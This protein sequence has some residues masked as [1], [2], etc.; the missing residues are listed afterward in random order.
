MVNADKVSGYAAEPVAWAV[1]AGLI[2]GSEV[3]VNGVAAKDLNPRGNTT[4]AQVATILQ[5]F[6]EKT[7]ETPDEEPINVEDVYGLKIAFEKETDISIYE[8]YLDADTTGKDDIGE[9]VEP[10]ILQPSEEVTTP[11]NIALGKPVTV[12]GTSDG[13]KSGVNDGTD[14]KWD[15]DPIKGS[16][17]KENSWVYVD[18]GADKTSIFDFMKIKY[19]NKIYPTLME[20]QISNDGKNWVTVSEFTREH[21]GTTYP[22]VDDVYEPALTARYV[23]LFFEELNSAAA[24][25]GVGVIEWEIQ[26]ITLSNVSVKSVAAVDGIQAAVNTSAANLNLP[27][28]V[29]VVLKQSVVGDVEVLV[30]VTWDTANYNGSAAGTYTLE[31]TLNLPGTVSNSGALKAS[32]KVTV[33]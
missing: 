23:R 30:P 33:Q 24:G 8:I 3:T 29:K 32:V 20:V 2:S 28:F 26:G 16:N 11:S 31:G 4:R 14:A 18:L 21:N 13:D 25:N 5:R 17:A 10:V 12:S 1:G 9:Y 19:F 7:D 27:S 6:C 15:S 22:V